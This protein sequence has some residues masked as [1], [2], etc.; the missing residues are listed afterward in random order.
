LNTCQFDKEHFTGADERNDPSRSISL[1]VVIIFHSFMLSFLL[2]FGT[3]KR[4]GASFPLAING[5]CFRPS[6]FIVRNKSVGR[7][8]ATTI[9]LTSD[10][11][12]HMEPDYD[13]MTRTCSVY[14]S[15]HSVQ[16]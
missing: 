4:E 2:S 11:E 15:F 3:S 10:T 6:R 14:Q 1:Y 7:L 8:N 5:I 9:S 12:L 16:S 13:V